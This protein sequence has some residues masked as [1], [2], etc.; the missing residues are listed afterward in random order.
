M[1]N[2]EKQKLKGSVLSKIK[3]IKF[4][5]PYENNKFIILSILTSAP[6]TATI[7]TYLFSFHSP[8]GT[9]KLDSLSSFLLGGVLFSLLPGMAI[10]YYSRKGRVDVELSQRESRTRFYFLAV[11]LQL[12]AAIIYY[13]FDHR[14]MFVTSITY[15]IATTLMALINLKWKISAHAS[16]IAGPV[17]ALYVVYG[18]VAIPL[19]L[20]LI[21]IFILRYKVKAHTISQ[22]IGGAF[23]SIIIT[24][25]V[26]TYMLY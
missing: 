10:L 25:F 17:T 21:P 3:G 4:K 2:E 13:H 20:L 8:Y 23:L 26:F 6:I 14:L 15:A 22:L 11:V 9:G 24:Y 16:G 5:K 19:Y 1:K 7:L 12:M 18:N